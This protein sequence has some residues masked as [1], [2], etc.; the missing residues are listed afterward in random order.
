MMMLEII[1]SKK[2]KDVGVQGNDGPEL[3]H[4]IDK[5]LRLIQKYARNNN[6]NMNS[7]VNKLKNE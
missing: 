7:I 5:K 4:Y 3:P 1:L 2:D 6:V